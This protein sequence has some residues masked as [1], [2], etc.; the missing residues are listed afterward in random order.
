MWEH[1]LPRVEIEWCTEWNTDKHISVKNLTL[2]RQLLEEE[3]RRPGEI[4]VQATFLLKSNFNSSSGTP[5]D[6]PGGSQGDPEEELRSVFKGKVARN[7]GL[8]NGFFQ[9]LT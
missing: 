9:F 4:M 1:L 5:W 7:N 8:K 2:H 6:P 3:N